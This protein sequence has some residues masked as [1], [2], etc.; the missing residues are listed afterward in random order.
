MVYPPAWLPILVLFPLFMVTNAMRMVSQST[1]MTKIPAQNERAAFM[2]LLSAVQHF[3]SASGAFL[4]SAILVTHA[5]GSLGQMPVVG[6]VAIALVLAG[7]PLMWLL[8]KRVKSRVVRDQG[9]GISDQN[10]EALF[11]DP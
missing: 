6:M 8:E 1:L 9:S 5:D 4:S 3:A 7:P 2:A 11:A 10:K